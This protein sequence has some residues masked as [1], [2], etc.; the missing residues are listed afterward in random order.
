MCNFFNLKLR[1]RC[2]IGLSICPNHEQQIIFKITVIII[3]VI[4]KVIT[5]TKLIIIVTITVIMIIV[6]VIRA[7]IIS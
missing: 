4:A 6:A 1:L 7:I 2:F 3:I 5:I